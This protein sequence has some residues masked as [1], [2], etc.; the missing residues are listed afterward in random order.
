MRGVAKPLRNLQ[1]NVFSRHDRRR[2]HRP[3]YDVMI[4]TTGT[5]RRNGRLKDALHPT[6]CPRPREGHPL[7]HNPSRKT[8]DH[9]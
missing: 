6:P 1:P 4:K 9:E 3:D 7:P 5:R 8:E 2:T